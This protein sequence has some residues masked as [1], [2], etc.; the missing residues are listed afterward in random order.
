MKVTF[1]GHGLKGSKE[2]VGDY[3]CSS[4]KNDS[5]D[6]FTIF[7][8]FT[9]MYG[10]NIFKKE[11]LKAKETYKEIKFYLG[12]VER[13]TSKEVLDFLIENN[14]ETWIFYTN[15]SIMFYPKIY[16]FNGKNKGRFIT[17]SSNLTKPGL[18]SNIEASTLL[19]F[20]PNNNQSQKFLN[21]F[22]DYFNSILNGTDNNTEKL[23][24]EVLKDLIEAGFVYDE[25]NTNDDF[26]T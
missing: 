23:N 18:I 21:Q 9:R 17:G 11:L 26:D 20:N 5:Y 10:I 12:I 7:L 15:S 19:E 13:G 25:Q 6:S 2:T 3:I 24:K 8:A 14:I 1:I 16:F 4:L 22:Y